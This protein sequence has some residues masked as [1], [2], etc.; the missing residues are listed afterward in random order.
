MAREQGDDGTF[1]ILSSRT[2]NKR[3]HVVPLPAL[4][5]AIIASV[6]AGREPGGLRIHDQW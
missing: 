2:K 3:P 5:R 1:V 4:A 6:K